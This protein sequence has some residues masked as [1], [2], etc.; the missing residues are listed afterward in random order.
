N[1][2]GTRIFTFGVGHDLNAAFLDQL[3]ESTWAVSSYVRPEEDIEI[4]VSGFFA[5]VNQPV[6]TNLKLAS[7]SGAG[8]LEIYPPK[9]PDLFFGGQVIVLGRYHGTGPTTL[10]LTGNVGA[11]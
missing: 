3:A 1:A 7:V 5:K 11:A 8:L 6:L 4:K 2:E 9:L 10:R